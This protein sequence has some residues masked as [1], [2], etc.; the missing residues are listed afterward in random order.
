MK[1]ILLA[2]ALTIILG[3]TASAQ[4]DG[5][6]KW[7]NNYDGNER[8]TGIDFSLPNA[9]GDTNDHD[10]PLGDGLLILGVLGAGYSMARRNP[11]TD[12]R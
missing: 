7:N 11:K 6:F 9:H 4:D 1:K 3:L 10:V 12:R 2:T 5:F 8:V